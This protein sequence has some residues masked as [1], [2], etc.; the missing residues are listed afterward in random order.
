MKQQYSIHDNIY[1][2]GIVI[3]DHE[4][5]TAIKASMTPEEIKRWEGV[6][7]MFNCDCPYNA[8][9]TH[10]PYDLVED[11]ID[12]AV[13]HRFLAKKYRPNDDTRNK[14]IDAIR[15]IVLSEGEN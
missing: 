2:R 5:M 9:Y 11:L 4:K 1:Q 3:I 10:M 15:E 12:W 7:H 13:D 8:A 14:A 6:D